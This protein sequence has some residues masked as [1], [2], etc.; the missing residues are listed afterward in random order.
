MVLSSPLR[1]LFQRRNF[2]VLTFLGIKTMCVGI[3]SQPKASLEHSFWRFLFN[4]YFSVAVCVIVALFYMCCIDIR[5]SINVLTV[6]WGTGTVCTA[7]VWLM[8]VFT[9]GKS[10]EQTATYPTCHTYRKNMLLSLH[11]LLRA[12]W[13]LFFIK[14]VPLF[15]KATQ[16]FKEAILMKS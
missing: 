12:T 6:W 8:T 10:R 9:G 16:L 15:L 7:K 11:I 14:W 3:L 5:W 13:F 4:I 1:L 2:W